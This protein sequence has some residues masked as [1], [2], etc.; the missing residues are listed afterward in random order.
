MLESITQD[1]DRT[2]W[3][4]LGGGDQ[5]LWP[6]Q[7]CSQEGGEARLHEEIIEYEK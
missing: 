6:P 7:D 1:Q 5:H 4:R 2:L 3:Q